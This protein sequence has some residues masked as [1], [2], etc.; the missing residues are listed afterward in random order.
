MEVSFGPFSVD[1]AAARVVRDGGEIRMRPRAFQVLRVLL[2]HQGTPVGYEQMIAEAWDGTY[3][4]RHTVDVTVA[5]V[6]KSLGEYGRWILTRPK[7]GFSLDIPSSEELV[8]MGWHLWSHRTRE[9]GERALECFGRAARECPGDF[10]AWEGLSASYLMLATFGI[11]PPRGMYRGFLEAHDRAIALAGP[12]PELRCNLAFAWHI[13]ER[14]AGDAERELRAVIAERPSFAA[15]HGRLAMVLGSTGRGDEAVE[16][17]TECRRA[18]PL[19]FT[20][21]AA[22][23]LIHIWRRDFTMAADVAARTVELHPYQHIA[24]I[25]YG[26][27]LRGVGRYDAALAQFQ[28]AVTISPDIPWLRTLESVCLTDVKRIPEATAIL[29]EL[30]EV[31]ERDY[32]DAYHLAA[33]YLALGL[34]DQAF[35]ELERGCEENSAWLYT[36]DVDPKMDDLRSDARFAR[37]RATVTGMRS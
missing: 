36:L 10:R 32:V 17:V 8:R 16:A 22:E 18:D 5:E 11:Q 1:L 27:A 9:G 13:F 37:V 20:G 23:A 12:R 3:V 21:A 25:S 30:Q 6:R 2:R 26:E 4:S 28:Q 33:A 14:R 29:E 7:V 31:R 19:L 34:R 15:A 24:R 35:A